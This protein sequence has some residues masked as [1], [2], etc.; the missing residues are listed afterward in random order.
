LIFREAHNP[1][2]EAFDVLLV[3]LFDGEIL[4]ERGVPGTIG[5]EQPLCQLIEGL[6]LIQTGRK[7]INGLQVENGIQ[8]FQF[9]TAKLRSGFPF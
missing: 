8:F 4:N 2:Q 7:C 9:F 1:E 6:R 5:G 3:A